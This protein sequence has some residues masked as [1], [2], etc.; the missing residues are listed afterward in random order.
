MLL[1]M[2]FVVSDFQSQNSKNCFIIQVKQ[3]N[4]QGYEVILV[5]SG[6]VGVGRQRLQYRKLIHSRLPR[7]SQSNNGLP[8]S[9][10]LSIF[11]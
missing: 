8:L 11:C 7:V 5:T 2:A 3:L 9:S 10:G 4:F 1:P 6:A